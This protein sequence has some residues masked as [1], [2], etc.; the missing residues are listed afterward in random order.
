MTISAGDIEL[1]KSVSS[2]T[3]LTIIVGF[4]PADS[5]KRR[6]DVDAEANTMRGMVYEFFRLPKVI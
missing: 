5:S 6:L 4:S 3:W 2:S 1:K